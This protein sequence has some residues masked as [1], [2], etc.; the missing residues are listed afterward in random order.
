ME[1]PFMTMMIK[2]KEKNHTFDRSMSVDFCQRIIGEVNYREENNIKLTQQN[3][4]E[5]VE[6]FFFWHDNVI[7][8]QTQT[9]ILRKML[10][11]ADLKMAIVAVGIENAEPEK[12][13]KIVS[14]VLAANSKAVEDYKAGKLAA[15]NRLVG[16]FL[17]KQKG[18]DPNAARKLIES[19]CN[20][21]N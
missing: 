10:D 9:E 14:D 4:N 13:E 19:E 16:E 6:L 12:L 21:N 18:F 17:K 5:Y 11:G 2:M 8:R 7:T 1:H 15:M 3:L 20:E